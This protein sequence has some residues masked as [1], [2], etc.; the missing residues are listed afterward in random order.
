[1]LPK[2]FRG[3]L[4]YL[5]TKGK[6]LRIKKEVDVKY[7]IAAGIRKISDTDGPALLFENIRGYPGWRVAGGIYGTKKLMALALE[8]EPDEEKILQRYLD[9]KD[10]R[11]KPKLVSTGPVK[12]IILKGGDIDLTKMPFPTYCEKDGGPY[13][14]GCADIAKHP[15]TGIQNVSIIRG[16]LLG[17]KDKRSL[18]TGPPSHLGLTIVANEERG[19]EAGVATVLGAPPELTIASQVKPPMGVDE[20]EIAGA[21]RGEPMEMVK[22]ETID[23]EVP[24]HAEVIIEAVTIPGSTVSD[25]PFG[26]WHG[27]YRGILPGT[28]PIAV[29]APE[30]QV[31]AITMRKDPIL[32]ALACGM[33]MT[34]TQWIKKWALTAGIYRLVTG[35]IPYPDDI[36]GINL[37]EGGAAGDNLVV[38]ICKR[39]EFQPRDIIYHVLS[40]GVNVA[41]VIIVDDDIDVYNPVDVEWAW[42]HRVDPESDIVIIPRPEG[43]RHGKKWGMDATM[44]IKDR[45]WESKARPPGVD[46]VDYV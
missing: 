25:G 37:T 16:M 13:I 38:S 41:N 10:K 17:K 5:E 23:V 30:M 46:K 4:D 32:Q 22:C 12:E 15:E 27:D 6:L 3:Y 2:D 26:E 45:E 18:G 19:K 40:G 34:E 39:T 31:T 24:A 33:P 21:F 7:E 28:I 1:M 14:I 20:T 9:C 36:K 35:I 42:A 11:V 43:I 8:T 29:G 44:S